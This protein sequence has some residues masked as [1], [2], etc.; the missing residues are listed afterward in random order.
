MALQLKYEIRQ[1]LIDAQGPEVTV[2]GN[3]LVTTYDDN[4]NVL[5]QQSVDTPLYSWSQL[6]TPIKNDILALRDHLIAALK[7]KYGTVA[8]TIVTP[9]G[10]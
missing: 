4:G 8:V 5:K 9:Q 7:T 2:S 1:F 3:V 10:G 6:S